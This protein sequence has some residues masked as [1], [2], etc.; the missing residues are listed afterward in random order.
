MLD[1]LDPKVW[2]DAIVRAV[3]ALPYGV[4]LLLAF[5]GIAIVRWALVPFVKALRG[6]D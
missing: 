5:A 2:L 1:S 3:D 4:E 6:R